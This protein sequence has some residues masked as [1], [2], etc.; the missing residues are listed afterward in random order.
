M[1]YCPEYGTLSRIWHIVQNVAHCLILLL[2]DITKVARHNK[3]DIGDSNHV[4]NTG[5]NS[6]S[7]S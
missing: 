2:R 6:G 1:A 3:L 4:D 7:G 5:T